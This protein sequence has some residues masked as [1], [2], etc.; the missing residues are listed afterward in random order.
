[1]I[2]LMFALMFCIIKTFPHAQKTNT[3]SGPTQLNA[4]QLLKEASIVLEELKNANKAGTSF[5]TR[6]T[7]LPTSRTIKRSSN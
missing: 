1:M 7:S 5:S 2:M 3:S 6:A 4:K